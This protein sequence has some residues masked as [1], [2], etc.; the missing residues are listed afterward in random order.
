M[1]DLDELRAFL[2]IVEHGSVKAA[3]DVLGVPRSTLRRRIDALE[4]RVGSPLLWAD[5]RGSRLSPK[6]RLM[7]E[8]AEALLTSYAALLERARRAGGESP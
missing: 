3:A 5:S 1:A 4:Q 7:I 2:A 6:G 8:E